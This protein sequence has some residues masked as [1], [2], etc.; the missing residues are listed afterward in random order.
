[1]A[2]GD[3]PALHTGFLKLDRLP[4]VFVGGTVAA[5]KIDGLLRAPRS[6]EEIRVRAS[7]VA[8]RLGDLRAKAANPAGVATSFSF[9]ARVSCLTRYSS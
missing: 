4:V 5:S 1:M 8:L 2:H 6:V 9:C 7:Q 3:M